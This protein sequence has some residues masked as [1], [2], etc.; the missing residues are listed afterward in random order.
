MPHFFIERPIF[1]WVVSIFI[2]LF[3]LLTVTRL[4]VELYPEI[5]PTE[6]TVTAIYPGATPQTL[7]DAVIEPIERE[8]T[9]VE[10]L[11]YFESSADT[12]G[13]ATVTVTFQPGTNHEMAQVQVQ[14]KVAQ[15]EPR[16]PQAVRTLGLTVEAAS[17]TNLMLIALTSDDGQYNSVE[18]GDY[19]SR[20]VVEE[21]KRIDGVGRVQVYGAPRALRVWV[22]PARLT[23]YN[24]GIDEIAAAIRSQNTMISPGRIGDRPSVDGQT[25]TMPLLVR[26]E[27]ESPEEFENIILRSNP[28]GSRVLLS[29]VADIEL[30]A[31]SYRA[32]ARLN[33]QPVSAAGVLLSPGANAVATANLVYERMEE[34]AQNFPAG[35]NYEIPFDTAPYV[36]TSLTKVMMT[37]VEA[38]LLVFLI[39]FLFLQN[40]RATFI[41]ALVA[42]IALL[43][44]FGV[45]YVTGYSVNT[46]TMFGMILSIGIIV[47][48]AI[49][50]VENVERIM[51]EERLPAKEAT[52]KAMH[53]IT[54]AVIGITLVLTAVFLPIATASGAIGMIYRQFSLSMAVAI[55]FSAFLALSL[56]PAL[57]A[58]MLKPHTED[59][60]EK[61]GFF[62]WFNRTFDRFT[63][64][65][66]G[67]VGWLVRRGGRMMIVYLAICV[68]A[69]WMFIRLPSSFLPAED[70]GSWIAN[71]QL[72]NDATAERTDALL[73]EYRDYILERED[74]KSIVQIQGFGFSGSGPNVGLMFSNMEDFADRKGSD[75]FQEVALA[76]ARFAGSTDGQITNVVPPSIRSLGNSAGFAMRLVDPQNQGALAL[77]DAE[78]VVL[79]Q[80]YMSEVVAYAYPEGLGTGPMIEVNIDRAA[81]EAQGIPFSSIGS[82]ISA[83]FGSMYINDFPNQG[84]QQQVIIQ[85]RAD[86]RMQIDDILAMPVAS[87]SGQ[88]VPLASVASAE[89]VHSP[90]QMVRYNGHPGR[91]IG[92]VAAPGFSSGEAMAEMERIVAEHL[93]TYGVEWTGLSYQERLSGAEAPLLMLLSLLVVFLVLAALYES[94]SIPFSVLLVVP[95]GVLG[96]LI[97]VSWRGLSNDIFF[98]VGLITLIGL[99][100]KNAVLIV[101]FAKQLEEEQGFSTVKAAVEAAKLRLRPILMTSLAFGL[102]V[103]PMVIASGA[104]AT[105]QHAIGTGVVGGMVSGT[106]LAVLFVPVFYVVVR[107]IFSSKSKKDP[108]PSTTP[109]T[110]E[111][112][113]EA[114]GL[115]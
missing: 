100:A 99:T 83:A 14:N 8:I 40:V 16:L 95:L 18:L 88:M 97:A 52:I 110:P 30:G 31:E 85:A 12:S 10:N 54:G 7:N 13:R 102:G 66:T 62:G 71:V 67:W 33:G 45:M 65:Y 106:V 37:F 58:T 86:A 101:E 11:L 50:V 72:E 28:D 19:F 94:W 6:V 98:K 48:D 35:V 57:C 64:R 63:N 104:S 60:K 111:L 2:I 115:A 68:G 75:V 20:A 56:T 1:A 113:V 96:A 36:Q 77:L 22:D 78:A 108:P 47:D 46:L 27:L 17:A 114:G 82:T 42:P 4:P 84:R 23:A 26:G 24:I 74:V 38:L 41:P 91:R 73:A 59:N 92:G 25:V 43:G 112:D 53:E 49:V 32:A 81:A 103:V 55:L 21:I 80:A 29:D 39:M 90:L 34:I 69:G 93:P 61:R 5:A 44:T 3:G 76:N 89:V 105:T 9:A 87:R 109:I 51:Q 70:Q 15:I 79:Q 107:S